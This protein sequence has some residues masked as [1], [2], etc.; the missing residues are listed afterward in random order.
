MQGQD[1]C[2][3]SKGL[4]LFFSFKSFGTALHFVPDRQII[5]LSFS[6]FRFFF[7]FK[8]IFIYQYKTHNLAT[9]W[10]FFQIHHYYFVQI[11]SFGRLG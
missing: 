7:F 5:G 1:K 9:P 2:S 10:V 4:Q 6:F 11:V 8:N 3:D